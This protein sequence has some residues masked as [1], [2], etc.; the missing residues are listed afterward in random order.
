MEIKP[1]PDI[2]LL[3]FWE[4]P[5]KGIHIISVYLRKAAANLCIFS[6]YRKFREQPSNLISRPFALLSRD[7][8]I[9]ERTE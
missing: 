6:A 1:E 4:G 3:F 2:Y 9:A 5:L 7:A 8:E